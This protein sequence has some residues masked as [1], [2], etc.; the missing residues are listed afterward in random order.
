VSLISSTALDK[1][2]YLKSAGFY[3]N[4]PLGGL[5]TPLIVFIHVPEPTKK[6]KVADVLRSLHKKLDL[7]G[8]IIFAPAAVMFLL[9]IQWA[10][11]RYSWSSATIIGLFVGSGVTAL[12]FLAWEW[13]EGDNAMFPF[14]IVRKRVVWTSF[15]SYGFMLSMVRPLF[16]TLFG[17]AKLT[18]REDIH[19]KLLF[20]P[21]LPGRS[22]EKPN[23]QRRIPAT[24]RPGATAY[25]GRLWVLE[26]DHRCTDIFISLIVLIQVQCKKLATTCPSLSLAWPWLRLA[27]AC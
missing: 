6:P 22:R 18:K 17:A 13:R 5:I 10:G 23:P 11:L 9:A 14:S 19:N 7:V 20:A 3:I 27:M 16:Q 21:L 12:L 8:A 4:L 15:I 2:T 24:Q 1:F 26:Y 25:V